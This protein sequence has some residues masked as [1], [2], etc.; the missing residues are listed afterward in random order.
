MVDSV[1][2]SSVDL[3][4]SNILQGS[5]WQTLFYELL[6]ILLSNIQEGVAVVDHDLGSPKYVD[7]L[8]F[9]TLG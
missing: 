8:L 3:F 6:S 4:L 9:N 5:L 1:L 2:Q 7:L